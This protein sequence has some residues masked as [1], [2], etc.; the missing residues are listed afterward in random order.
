MLTDPREEYSPIARRFFIT[1]VSC[2]R[3]FCC[4]IE[5]FVQRV[6]DNMCIQRM[7]GSHQ[8]TRACMVPAQKNHLKFFYTLLTGLELKLKILWN[9]INVLNVYIAD[10]IPCNLNITCSKLF[11]HP[12]FPSV[13]IPRSRVPFFAEYVCAFRT[14]TEVAFCPTSSIKQNRNAAKTNPPK[15]QLSI[16]IYVFNHGSATHH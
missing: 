4:T 15:I 6:E 7:P 13:T 14:A 11:K 12:N 16:W 10:D 9:N 3:T 1:C 5:M 8:S 2:S